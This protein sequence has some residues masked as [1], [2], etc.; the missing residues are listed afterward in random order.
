MFWSQ[1]L[2]THNGKYLGLIEVPWRLGMH[3][4]KVRGQLI[5]RAVPQAVVWDTIE[6]VTIGELETILKAQDFWE[7]GS[8]K[9]FKDVMDEEIKS[10]P[11]M[12]RTT[13]RTVQ[14]NTL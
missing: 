13:K 6:N 3:D 11:S 1:I 8:T 7:F 9:L 14:L 2:L 4:D 10:C 12:E 5:H